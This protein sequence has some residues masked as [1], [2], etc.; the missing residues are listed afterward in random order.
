LEALSGLE[1][2]RLKGTK[3]TDEGFHKWLAPRESLN[4][5][6]LQGTQVT[7]ESGKA[8]KAARPGRRLLQ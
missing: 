8:W 5:L 7:K 2:L 1:T 3:I 6:D 4:Q